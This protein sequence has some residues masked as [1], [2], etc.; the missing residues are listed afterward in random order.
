MNMILGWA[1]R[2]RGLFADSKGPWGQNNAGSGSGGGTEPPSD[3]GQPTHGNGP[4]GEAPK[5]RRTAIG[6]GS[7]VTSLDE[8]LRKGRARF[9]RRSTG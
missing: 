6:S 1:G 2:V 5:R 9:P 8:L 4:W 7:N 3:E